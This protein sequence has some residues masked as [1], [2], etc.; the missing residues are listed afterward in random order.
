MGDLGYFLLRFSLSYYPMALIAAYY[1]RPVPYPCPM[2]CS[3]DTAD[4]SLLD[5]DRNC[6]P[7]AKVILKYRHRSYDIYADGDKES[8][9]MMGY[10][11]SSLSYD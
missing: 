1:G 8:W 4:I 7:L 2:A 10:I 9:E 6:G 11:Y 3:C 5:H